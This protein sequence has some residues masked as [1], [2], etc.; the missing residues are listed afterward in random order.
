MSEFPEP[1]TLTPALPLPEQVLEGLNDPQKSAVT[2]LGGPLLIVAGAGSGKTRTLTRRFEWLVAQGVPADR[3][4]ALTYTNDAAAE[5]AERIEQALGELPEEI[6]ATTF[7]SLCM[8]I[9]RD[10]S[11]PAGLNP[12]FT[13]A[14]A[15]DR[16]ALMLGRINE[17]TFD[18]IS[19]R[20]NP[21]AALGE[22]MSVIDRLKE[23]CISPDELAEYAKAALADAIEESDREKALLLAEQARLYAAHEKFLH[24]AA[25]LDFGGM[26]F[27]LYK[28]LAGNGTVR[29]RIARRFDHVLVDEFQD[30]S[31]VQ[32]EILKLLTQDHR[33][34]AAVG[35]DDQSIYRFRGASPRSILDFQRRFGEAT[36]IELELNYRSAPPII[37]AARA[38][39]RMIPDDRR[40]PKNLTAAVDKPGEVLFWHAESEVAEAQAIVTEIERLI[41]DVGVEPR[42]ICV[43]AHNRPHVRVLADRM[44]AH[45]IPYTL[46]TKDFFQRSE[47]RV[48][49]SWL[50]VLANPTL[51]EDAWRM[52]TAHPINLDSADYA[53]LMKW[54]KR[55]KQPHVVEAMR[56]AAR[57]KQFSPE[58]LDKIRQFITT[59]DTL[60]A[61]FNEQGPGE[62][63][64]RLINEIAIKGSVLLESGKDA[65]DR[66]ANLSKF[67]RLAEDYEGRSPQASARDFANY[68][69]GMAE[70][71]F[72]E[73]SESA[74]RD[75]NAV[76]LMTAHGS[77]GLEFEYVF[78]PG[79]IH[80][81]WPGNARGN[82]AVPP[83]L[84][85]DPMPPLPG[86]SPD[87]EAHIEETRRLAHV[88]MTRARTQLVLSWFD[89]DARGHKVSEFYSE[90]MLAVDGNEQEF[91]ERDFETADFVYA[92]METLRGELMGSIA[93]AGAQLGEMRLD[94]HA[95]TPDDFARFAELLKLSALVHRLRHGQTIADALPEVNDM[96]T[97]Q[98]SPAQRAAYE[99]SELDDR[100]RI[101]EER[102]EELSRK[103]GAITPQ[104]T[105]FLP[106][107][108]NRLRLSASAIGSYQRCPKQ[109]EYENVMK[110]PTPDQS[111][112]RL[113]ITVHNVLERF[114]KDLEEPLEPEDAR[115][116]IEGLLDQAVVTGGWGRTDDD[117]QLLERA[118]TMLA[119]YADSEFARP[120]G[121]VRT[122]ASFSLKL[123]PTKLME[124]TPVGGKLLDGIQIN[125]KIDRIDTLADGTQRV[126]DYKTG[127]DKK[128]AVALRNQVAKEIQLAIYKYAGAQE[129]GI[130]A[131]GLVYYFLENAQPVIEA[132]ATEEHVAEVRAQIN[133]VADK[134]ISLDFTPDPEH[135]KCRSCA[136]RHVCPAT[137]A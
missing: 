15:P 113:G 27:E 14:T 46:Q 119:R 80:G 74:E 12:F 2:H 10:E 82:K 42:E 90:A 32:L 75:P 31:Y 3:I 47:I 78:V 83:A 37:D 20:G 93:Q 125:G 45:D 53:G 76:R 57:S 51:N 124:T 16:V 121:P 79:M 135:Q 11:G 111:H 99:A 81:R 39:V 101:S 59:F 25:A 136:F 86:K 115:K 91:P 49:L 137:E 44:G 96:L 64:I 98:M 6:H 72:D 95:G 118:R 7:H 132:E 30:T 114:H 62:F 131:Q 28:L 65:P 58:T 130:D 92:E 89:S 9:L 126:I 19:L 69:T 33:N 48:P 71:G 52:L 110:I 8:E 17:L 41:A 87:R 133:E 13:T 29:A 1:M 84:L 123:P 56:G 94:A 127:N 88:A 38:I 105:N 4:L 35:D 60:N 40:V 109:Y 54:M 5:L 116:R 68:I 128:G 102:V 85:R 73:S 21:A 18:Q 120:E 106:T 36:R 112:L 67:Q 134:I 77:K 43:L 26:Q 23:E 129:L 122:E 103:I 117:R 107:I 108:G 104:L 22:L 63:T 50:K 61:N 34:L 66:L 55:D 24:D 97:S 70:A 100:L